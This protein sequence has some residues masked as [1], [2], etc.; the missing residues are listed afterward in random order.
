M[1]LG[2]LDSAIEKMIRRIITWALREFNISS[3]VE[4]DIT[5][6]SCEKRNSIFSSNHVLF[7]SLN[8]HLTN[9]KMPTLLKFQN[10]NALSLVHEEE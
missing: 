1:F 5:R 4:L 7:C 8:E 6:V 2:R 3:S 10:E 9:K